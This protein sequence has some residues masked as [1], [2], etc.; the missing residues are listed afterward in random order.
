MFFKYCATGV[1][2]YKQFVLGSF[3]KLSKSQPVTSGFEN[4][5]HCF[6]RA[7]WPWLLLRLCC[8]FPLVVR[9]VR[10][11]VKGEDGEG[12]GWGIEE[13]RKEE[14]R[15]KYCPRS[16]PWEFWNTPSSRLWLTCDV[17]VL[18]VSIVVNKWNFV[19]WSLHIIHAILDPRALLCCAWLQTRRALGNPVS[20][21]FQWKTISVS[22]WSIQVRPRAGEL[23]VWSKHALLILDF[24]VLKHLRDYLGRVNRFPSFQRKY[25]SYI[26]KID[27]E[28]GLN[29][30]IK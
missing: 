12:E 2:D 19:E 15:E 26:S 7:A 29:L 30:Q 25:V 16:T 5:L 9:I 10:A 27:R 4:H 21:S 1:C 24:S 22:D 13:G 23:A 11:E 3:Y 8:F 20:G 18:L 6:A 14:G 17:G 28:K